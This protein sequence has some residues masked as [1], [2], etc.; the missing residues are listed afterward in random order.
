MD[1]VASGGDGQMAVTLERFFIMVSGFGFGWTDGMVS[2][3]TIHLTKPYRV[4]DMGCIAFFS[5]SAPAFHLP[6]PALPRN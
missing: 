2:T 3:H 5:S 1:G 6:A 4:D